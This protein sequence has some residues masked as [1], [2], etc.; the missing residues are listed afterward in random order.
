M[1]LDLM[2][3]P[4]GRMAPPQARRRS[5]GPHQTQGFGTR[6]IVWYEVIRFTVRGCTLAIHDE[7]PT[8]N[9][10]ATRAISSPA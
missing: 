7:A 5:D 8:G 1:P 6:G 10:T 9:S 2:L 4:Q 3:L